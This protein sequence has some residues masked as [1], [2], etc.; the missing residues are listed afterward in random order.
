LTIIEVPA[1]V[2]DAAHEYCDWE[3]NDIFLYEQK[4]GVNAYYVIEFDQVMP[5][6]EQ[7]LHVLPN[8]TIVTA[9]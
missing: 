6:H 7:Q 5:Y 1:P 8:G 9:Y 2:I 3:I 4:K